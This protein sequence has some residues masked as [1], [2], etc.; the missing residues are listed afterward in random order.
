[1][2]FVLEALP[3]LVLVGAAVVGARSLVGRRRAG[4]ARWAPR[5]RSL[6]DNRVSVEVAREGEATQVVAQLD[7]VADDFDEQLFG[8]QARAEQLAATLNV[9][10]RSG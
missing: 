9:A 4:R 6:P 5:V 8:A 2:R 3:G 7:P 1:V 10:R